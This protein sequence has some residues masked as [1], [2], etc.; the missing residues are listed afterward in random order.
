M[1]R[2]GMST[3]DFTT[4]SKVVVA[5]IIEYTGAGVI[6]V[7]HSPQTE[8]PG[9]GVGPIGSQAKRATLTGAGYQVK[10]VHAAPAR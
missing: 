2:S 10:P 3:D 5:P 6:L 7:D 4:W 1:R 9:R 8:K